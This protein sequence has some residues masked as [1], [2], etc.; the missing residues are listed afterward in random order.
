MDSLNG[1]I[2]VDDR[3][4]VQLNAVKVVDCEGDCLGATEVMISVLRENDE[5]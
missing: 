1:L 2:Y 3:Q 4:V 5:R